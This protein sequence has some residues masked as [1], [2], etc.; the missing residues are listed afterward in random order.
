MSGTKVRALRHKHLLLA[1]CVLAAM[2][3]V[4]LGDVQ[5]LELFLLLHVSY[6]SICFILG[7]FRLYLQKATRALVA[8]HLVFAIAAVA[9][10]AASLRLNFY[11]PHDI[12]FLKSPLLLSAARIA[13][14]SL[15]AFYMVYLSASFQVDPDGRSYAMA[16]YFWSG[17]ASAAYSL[18]SYPVL[19]AAG[20]NLG[21][22]VP[23][24]R[25][26]GFFNEGGPYGLYLVGVM[27]V[28][29]L[30]HEDRTLSLKRIGCGSLV[31]A[32]AFLLSQ[33]KAA[34]MGC[35]LL[36]ALYLVLTGTIRRK[37]LLSAVAVLFVYV[38]VTQTPVVPQLVGYYD[39]YELLADF[40]AS[41]DEGAYGGFG[42]RLG[43][44][45]LVPRMIEAHPWTGIGMGNYPLVRND[46][47]YLRG[48]PTNDTWDLP[49]VG[50]ISYAAELGL[51]LFLA[52]MLLLF[53]PAWLTRKA[54]ALLFIA[55]L[56]QP[57]AHAFG[58]QLNF[59]YPWICS[60]FVLGALH[61]GASP[62]GSGTIGPAP[63]SAT[64]GFPAVTPVGMRTLSEPEV[65]LRPGSPPSAYAQRK[66]LCA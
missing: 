20:I 32:A 33:S 15:G 25:A 35:L 50:L 9:L 7:G 22:Y 36:F 65:A 63:L 8:G 47:R 29:L 46:P 43:G 10:A 16:V 13:E 1:V 12:S 59:Y 62:I 3:T 51:P 54:S 19:F 44:A 57:M 66:R 14:V 41:V 5:L 21:A 61:R 2:P 48:L 34:F 53:V 27:L 31:L 42:G 17:V 39:S 45:V 26:R 58:V 11:P 28:G 64:P 38:V 37:L 6:L 30:L 56:Y 55:G 23:G 49:G 52:M 24:F 40:G 4:R 60:A 18:I